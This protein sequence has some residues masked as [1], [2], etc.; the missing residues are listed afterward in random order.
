M[1]PFV[2]TAVASRDPERWA[3]FYLFPLGLSIVN[4][5]LVLVAFRE[6]VRV[7]PRNHQAVDTV[8]EP[9]GRSRG[10][11]LEI[12]Q[13]LKTGNLWIFYLFFFF[14]LGAVTTSGGKPSLSS[15]Q[16]DD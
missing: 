2:A 12:K 5:V 14:Y 15:Q 11:M 9:N 8:E 4:L 10:A 1:G 16:A 3:L 6:S 7:T 13:K